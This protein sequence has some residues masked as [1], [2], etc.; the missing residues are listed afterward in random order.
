MVD[1]SVAP[2]AALSSDFKRFWTGQTI[3]QLGSSFTQFATP[4][5]VFKLTHSAVN[6]G[7]AT[8]ATFVPYLL[9]G[10]VIGAWVDRV[11]RKRMMILV[12]LGRAAVIAM[13][14]LLSM[15]GVLE[16]WQV[17][18]VAFATSVLTIFFEA[19]EFAAIPSLVTTDDLVGANG[20][21]QASYSA[22]QVLG[23]LLAGVFLALVA[24]EEL[25]LVDASSFVVSAIALALVRRSFNAVEAVDQGR[26]T[27]IRED[28]VEGLRYVIRHP[29]LRNISLMM[30]L[31][32]FVGVT[33][34]TQLV[35]FSKER[36]SATDTEVG[37]LYSAGSLGVVALGLL[38]GRLRRRLKFGPAALGSL[39]LYGAMT[40]ALAADRMYWLA[41]VLWGLA[42]GVGIFFNI[43]TG[44][45]RQA[46]VP[47]A[48]L[49]R[50]M[51]IAG[52]LAWGA[53][54]LGSLLGGYVVHW[55]GSVAWVYGGIG[56][57]ECV[58]AAWFFFLSPLGHAEDYLPGGSL[59][60]DSRAADEAA[61][62]S[63]GV[64]AGRG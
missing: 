54:P 64:G 47:N 27:S 57:I 48:L 63:A 22:A 38:A 58:I 10:L 11:N 8:A 13:I 25:F 31:F 19:G 52:V 18:A 45:L 61:E 17:Y 32:N 40:V 51:S 12:D 62:E 35:L 23:P 30:A 28:V 20:K 39:A 59:A 34:T 26:R 37:V 9:F 4:L 46:I 1:A 53:I 3:S 16:V 56:I 5:L 15:F 60:G 29:V 36:L 49:G 14:P 6:L 33:Q 55:T 21:I 7:I 41:L 43:N 42:S 2:A 50:I 24:V 44:S